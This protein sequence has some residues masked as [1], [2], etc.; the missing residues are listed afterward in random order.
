MSNSIDN[1]LKFHEVTLEN[2]IEI[3]R[4]LFKA[5][6]ESQFKYHP[7]VWMFH[8]RQTNHKINR[9][10]ESYLRIC[11]MAMSQLFRTFYVKIINKQFIF[12]TFSLRQ[13]KIDKT[14][15]NLSGGTFEELFTQRP[16][17]YSVC[18]KQKLIIP[19][20][21]TILKGK[22]SLRYFTAI[23]KNLIPNDIK[24]IES[25]NNFRSKIKIS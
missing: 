22:Y 25:C 21:S 20:V 2:Y 5:F 15:N 16:D 13:K 19:K 14:L 10:H 18:L 7:H 1:L 24:N 3:R 4:T 6:I 9:L 12:Q 11:I 8:G 23:A 17:S